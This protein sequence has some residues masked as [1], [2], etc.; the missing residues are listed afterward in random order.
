MFEYYP[1]TS[2]YFRWNFILFCFVL[3]AAPVAYGHSRV[4]GQNG[5]AAIG[6]SHSHSN[7]RY[8]L[9]LWLTPQLVATPDPYPTEPTQGSNHH[10]ERENVVSLTCWATIGA[11]QVKFFCA[12]CLFVTMLFFIPTLPSPQYGYMTIWGSI[13]IQQFYHFDYTNIVHGWAKLSAVI[14]SSFL[15]KW[16]RTRQSE[17]EFLSG[18]LDK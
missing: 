12:V 15:E 7:I 13:C 5:D 16:F 14:I 17:L 8:E 4:R 10:P 2:S 11:Q 1:L 18:T 6:H 9:H 3:M